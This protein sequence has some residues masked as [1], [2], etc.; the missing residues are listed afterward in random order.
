ME[1]LSFR[2]IDTRKKIP[3][4]SKDIVKKHRKKESRKLFG[5]KYVTQM[6]HKES[7]KKK[8]RNRILFKNVE[9]FY[10]K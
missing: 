3:L 4:I 10:T 6:I 5:G 9:S 8:T 1:L 2:N 7:D